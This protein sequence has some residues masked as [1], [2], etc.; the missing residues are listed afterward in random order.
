M[1]KEC[2]RDCFH[3]IYEDCIV[4]TATA[5]EK[6]EIRERDNRYYKQG[7]ASFTI[8]ARPKLARHK[9]VRL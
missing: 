5:K 9:G 7:N 3:C 2:N 4:D 6:A 1:A 8:K